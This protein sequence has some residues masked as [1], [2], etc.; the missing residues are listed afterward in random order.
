MIHPLLVLLL[1][2]PRRRGAVEARDALA[3]RAA[4]HSGDQDSD[5]PRWQNG[6]HI[7]LLLI[8]TIIT[9]SSPAAGGGGGGSNC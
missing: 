2:A 4:W 8:I 3:E 1:P 5:E 7:D 9:S 6:A